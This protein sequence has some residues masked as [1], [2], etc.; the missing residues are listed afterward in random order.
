[1]PWLYGVATNVIRNHRRSIRRR[2]T[3]LLDARHLEREADFAAELDG[4]L[5]DERAM[6]RVLGL[7]GRLPRREQDALALCVWQGLSYEEAAAALDVPVGTVRSRL[8]RARRRLRELDGHVEVFPSRDSALCERIGLA[9]L[10]TGYEQAAAAF[11][12]M[13]D[14]L[15][16]RL[17]QAEATHERSCIPLAEAQGSRNSSSTCTTSPTGASRR[18]ASP[19]VA[20]V[21]SSIPSDASSAS[22]LARGRRSRRS[23]ERPSTTATAAEDRE[24][25]A[26][27][28]KPCWTEAF[29]AGASR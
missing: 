1:L 20:A 5:D 15:G 26:G 24:E 2:L 22:R 18:T 13:R 17:D 6:R 27:P 4:R 11:A 23:C 12:A 9:P 3:A 8:S 16:E 25:H 7:L 14:D 29:P 19:G 28:S 21:P 10:P